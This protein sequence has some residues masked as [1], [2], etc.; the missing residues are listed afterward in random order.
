MWTLIA[1][2]QSYVKNTFIC[3]LHVGAYLGTRSR[4]QT[5]RER[6]SKEWP[7]C[8][9]SEELHP[10]PP[11]EQLVNKGTRR[12]ALTVTVHNPCWLRERLHPEHRPEI[13][14]GRWVL[15]FG[16][17][18]AQDQQI[19]AQDANQGPW[20]QLGRQTLNLNRGT[21]T[22]RINNFEAHR[23]LPDHAR[24]LERAVH[25]ETSVHALSARPV[26]GT[27]GLQTHRCGCTSGLGNFPR[28]LDCH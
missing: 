6:Q 22:L 23:R 8:R 28:I 26:A 20:G 2:D 7:C 1:A 10:R 19:V 25:D 5:W 16:R 27:P 17:V 14:T 13:N 3:T 15:P 11:G 9:P 24:K 18:P 21:V 4:R 12:R